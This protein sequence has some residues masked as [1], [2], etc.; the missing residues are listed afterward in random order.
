MKKPSLCDKQRKFCNYLLKGLPKKRAAIKAGYS[1]KTAASQASQMLQLQH[2]QDYL[3]MHYE[4]DASE[5]AIEREIVRKT[6]MNYITAD[7]SAYFDDEWNLLPKI[8][9]PK[10]IRELVL[11]V[12]KWSSEEQGESVSVK[13]PNK[14]DAIKAYLRFFPVA[15]KK[16]EDL[17]DAAE[18][19]ETSLEELIA[20]L[21]EST[22]GLDGTDSP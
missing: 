11:A 4:R 17:A 22:G 19:V 12:K 2:V 20:R 21:E 15:E 1:A 5:V 16:A 7:L 6:L 14:L 8:Q 10:R 18:Q 9:V 13:L 3:Q